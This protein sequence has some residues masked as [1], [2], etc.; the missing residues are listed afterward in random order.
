MRKGEGHRGNAA[1][2]TP[3]D[4]RP[5][6]GPR[7]RRPMFQMPGAGAC[8]TR[9]PGPNCMLPL[10]PIRTPPSLLPSLEG[11]ETESPWHGAVRLSGQRCGGE[12]PSW[13]HILDGIRIV[14]PDLTSPDAHRLVSGA[15]FIQRLS[16]VDWRRLL[17]VT[18]Q[19]PGGVSVTWRRPL[20][21]N[22]AFAMHRVT[23]RL[24]VRGVPFG[25]R[26][27]THLE[28]ILRPAGTLRK[29]VSNGIQIGDLNCVCLDV[30][31]DGDKEIPNIILTAVEG[32]MDTKITMAAQ[33]PPPPL[34]QCP[35]LVSSLSPTMRV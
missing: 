5:L 2:T 13:D 35:H 10:P 23:K 17:G 11:A 3:K 20:S 16:K 29:I 26:T 7:K 28:R 9:M 6:C 14:C 15:I 31:V 12:D 21:S 1:S 25:L 4:V 19:I 8:S 24:K 22:E 27:W 32:G 18:Q 33:P 30:E 34:S